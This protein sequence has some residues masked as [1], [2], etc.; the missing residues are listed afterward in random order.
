MFGPPTPASTGVSFSLVCRA[1][2]GTV[3][4]VLAQLTT[5]ERL[6]GRKILGLTA[7]AKRHSKRIVIG[8]KRFILGAG[9]RTRLVVPLNQAGGR[10]LVR[11]RRIPATLRISLLNSSPPA[12]IAAK[13][14]ITA[15][16]Q[17][18]RH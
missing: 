15:K 11:F 7:R 8:S 1:A 9:Q 4:G 13:V 17:R 12:V 5:T 14:S 6:L 18:K 10:L 16:K 2:P 3:C